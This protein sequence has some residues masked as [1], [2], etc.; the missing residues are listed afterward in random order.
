MTDETISVDSD[1]DSEFAKMLGED[2]GVPAVAA[3]V[4][5]VAAP[6]AP[7]APKAPEGPNPYGIHMRNVEVVTMTYLRKW[8]QCAT[9]GMKFNRA[10]NITRLTSAEFLS[11]HI[12]ITTGEYS[13]LCHNDPAWIDPAN[14]EAAEPARAARGTMPKVPKAPKEKKG[15]T[16]ATAETTAAAVAAEQAILGEAVPEPAP[17]EFETPAL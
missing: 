16:V 6:K 1:F 13:A 2:A 9:R 4:A 11:Q 17:A 3:P 15:K 14:P 5:K 7:K 12:G 10:A 8:A